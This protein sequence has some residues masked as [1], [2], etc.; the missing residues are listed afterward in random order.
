MY[1]HN[2]CFAY[3]IILLHYTSCQYKPQRNKLTPVQSNTAISLALILQMKRYQPHP[4]TRYKSEKGGRNLLSKTCLKT[5]WNIK[6]SETSVWSNNHM[7]MLAFF[8]RKNLSVLVTLYIVLWLTDRPFQSM[9]GHFW[10][11]CAWQVFLLHIL[12]HYVLNIHENRMFI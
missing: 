8:I 9:R 2:I 6:K 3:S 11:K 1:T 7:Y 12:K 4:S 5:K 10:E